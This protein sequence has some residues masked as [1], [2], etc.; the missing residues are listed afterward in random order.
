LVL[1]DLKATLEQLAR[2]E[3][4]DL[5]VLLDLPEPTDL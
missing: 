4:L 3:P 1:L 2:L 5:L